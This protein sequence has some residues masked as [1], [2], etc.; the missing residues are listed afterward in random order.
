MELI[1]HIEAEQRHFKMEKHPAGRQA[2]GALRLHM[3]DI[4]SAHFTIGSDPKHPLSFV[5]F[6]VHAL[7][8]KG[9]RK[10]FN[11]CMYG[12]DRLDLVDG[13]VALANKKL[14]DAYALWVSDLE[15]SRSQTPPRLDPPF[16]IKMDLEAIVAEVAETLGVET[17]APADG[18]RFASLDLAP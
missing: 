1:A 2:A 8:A 16:V 15:R 4:A 17:S 11:S 5:I 9:K 3:A 18:E 10:S 6:E 13:I 14:S 12:S 7:N